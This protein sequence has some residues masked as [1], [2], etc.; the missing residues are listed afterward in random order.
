MTRAFLRARLNPDEERG[1]TI[2]IVVLS[3]FAIISMLILTVDVGGLLLRRRSMVNVADSASLAAAQTCSNRD[4][5]RDPATVANTYANVNDSGLNASTNP[6]VANVNCFQGITAADKKSSGWVTVQYQR[7]QALFFAGVLG[8][9]ANQQVT[10]AATA[11]FGPSAGGNAVPVVLES[12]QLQGACKVP[13]GIA[14][15][16]TCAFWYDNNTLGSAD[17]GFMNLDEWNV[18]ASTNCSNAGSSSRSD[19][20]INNY[21]T[22]LSLNGN[23]LGSAPTYVCVDT[24]HSTSDWQD[25]RSQSFDVTNNDDLSTKLFPVNDCSGQVDKSGVVAP[26]PTTPDK[27]D[28]IGFTKLEI[29]HVWKGNDTQAIGTAGQSGS[30]SNQSLP[31]GLISGSTVDLAAFAHAN[32][33][34]P[35]VID[36]L[37]FDSNFKVTLKVGPLT[38][39]YTGC[40]VGT[41]LPACVGAYDYT[42]DEQTKILTWHHL[43]STAEKISFSW[44]TNGSPGDCG[45]RPSDPNALCLVTKWRG[46]STGPGPICPS[47]TGFGVNNIL[48]CDRTLATCP[49]Q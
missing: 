41:G 8:F 29:L 10:G 2:V 48:L 16:D 11:A 33:G 6:I 12:G 7:P 42:Y 36:N 18:T 30:C 45:I 35:S 38:T 31:A 1:A 44:S 40:K 19:W 4:D 46:F 32:C 37:P 20:I 43:P 34:A 13:D 39:T 9:G 25:L 28:V 26:C 14:I 27:Y 5:N 22:P 49:G 17:W 24:G 3:L 47:C 21:P 23:P 15:G